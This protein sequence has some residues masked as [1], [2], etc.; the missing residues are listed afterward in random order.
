LF[1]RHGF[2]EVGR[3]VEVGRKFERWRTQLLFLRLVTSTRAV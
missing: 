1:E 2:A 3:L